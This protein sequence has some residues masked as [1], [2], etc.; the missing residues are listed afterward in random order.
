MPKRIHKT[1]RLPAI[2]RLDKAAAQR[3]AA[4]VRDAREKAVAD[5]LKADAARLYASDSTRRA[6]SAKLSADY[7]GMADRMDE[8]VRDVGGRVAK[9]AHGYVVDD[10]GTT[11]ALSAKRLDSAM[12]RLTPDGPAGTAMA[13]SLAKWTRSAINEAARDVWRTGQA[14]GWSHDRCV[15]EF[16]DRLRGFAAEMAGTKYRAA[17]GR[18]ID[19]RVYVQTLSRTMNAQLVRE[20]YF[21]ECCRA[22]IDLVVI[23]N[24]EDENVCSVCAEWD[25]MIVS[26]TGNDDRFPAL[27]EAMKDGWGHPNCRCHAEAVDAK[28]DA[29]LIDAQAE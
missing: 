14:K 10:T 4:I 17:N 18:M 15:R 3:L 29:D 5:L 26:L 27:A 13:D 9:L 7:S 19:E 28:R 23:E 16:R 2:E 6:V 21:D 24:V 8:A 20:V 11:L 25:R 12:S 1:H 22:G